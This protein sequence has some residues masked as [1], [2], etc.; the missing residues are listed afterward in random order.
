MR[1][2]QVQRGNNLRQKSTEKYLICKNGSINFKHKSNILCQLDNS[3]SANK[4]I[5]GLAFFKSAEKN[6]FETRE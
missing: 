6:T 4:F 1:S 2:L 3:N 5:F